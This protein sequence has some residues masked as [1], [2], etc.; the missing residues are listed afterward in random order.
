MHPYRMRGLY[1]DPGYADT[2]RRRNPAID[3]AMT[4]RY[5]R[6]QGR[7]WRVLD[8]PNLSTVALAR[9]GRMRRQLHMLRGGLA[10]VAAEFADR[11]DQYGVGIA[12]RVL[13]VDG[14]GEFSLADLVWVENWQIWAVEQQNG[15]PRALVLRGADAYTVPLPIELFALVGRRDNS[16]L[17]EG[18]SAL[19]CLWWRDEDIRRMLEDAAR[20]R[21]RIGLGKRLWKVPASE[22]AKPSS[23]STTL[24]NYIDTAEQRLT[25]H[26][27]AYAVIPAEV[28]VEWDNGPTL[29]PQYESAIQAHEHAIARQFGDTLSEEGVAVAGARAA[30]VEQRKTA[31]LS[32]QGQCQAVAR[33]MT[34]ELIWPIYDLNGWPREEAP[35]I[36]ATGFYDTDAVR[37]LIELL[38]EDRDRV[39]ANLAPVLDDNDL[40]GVRQMVRLG[41]NLG[42]DNG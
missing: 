33:A 25:R 42:G 31:D 28:D 21:A 2:M 27:E 4:A 22:L 39:A 36:Q 14:A 1:P 8:M 6:H 24:R 5:Y 11:A 23:D 10:G 20:A 32:E 18:H 15:F 9:S 30:V 3:S 12:E 7:P 34:R 38:R 26:E 29:Q 13:Y 16:R 41:F 35:E 40:A 37:A 17:P 19:R